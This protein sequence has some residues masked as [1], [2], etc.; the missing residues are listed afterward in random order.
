MVSG[1]III[2]AFDAKT[3]LMRLR[4][5]SPV[6]RSVIGGVTNDFRLLHLGKKTTPMRAKEDR[7]LANCLKSAS[8]KLCAQSPS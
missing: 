4:L 6:S 5:F 1:V 2:S 8:T 3:F 7:P